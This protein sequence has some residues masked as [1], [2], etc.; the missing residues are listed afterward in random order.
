MNT[1]LPA[2]AGIYTRGKDGELVLVQPPIG[3]AEPTPPAAPAEQPT[4]E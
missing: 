2:D 1:P 3:S 4:G